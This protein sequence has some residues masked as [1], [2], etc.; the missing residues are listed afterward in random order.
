MALS[1]L[2]ELAETLRLRG[3]R[4]CLPALEKDYNS[5]LKSQLCVC[6]R[7]VV[8]GTAVLSV[9]HALLFRSLPAK[10]LLGSHARKAFVPLE[11]QVQTLQSDL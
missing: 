3:A 6:P 7:A 4:S 9:T 1:P 10:C 5:L 8:K 11:G 2:Y